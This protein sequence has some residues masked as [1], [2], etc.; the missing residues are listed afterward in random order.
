VTVVRVIRRTTLFIDKNVM[1][2]VFFFFLIGHFTA[3]PCNTY[4]CGW[5]KNKKR[6]EKVVFTHLNR[7]TMFFF[8]VFRTINISIL[9]INLIKKS[10]LYNTCCTIPPKSR[11]NNIF[12]H[13]IV[14]HLNGWP[15]RTYR[16]IFFFYGLK[17]FSLV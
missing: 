2:T 8:Q 16:K 12:P 15:P 7:V 10:G 3:P 17:I 6:L 9:N 14:L 11:P 5:H 1:L 4:K 13:I